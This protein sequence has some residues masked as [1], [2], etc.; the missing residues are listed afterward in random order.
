MVWQRVRFFEENASRYTNWA[1]SRRI[2]SR[3]A[4]HGPQSPLS[5][6]RHPICIYCTPLV[7]AF[8]SRLDRWVLRWCPLV[9]RY[10]CCCCSRR[11]CRK[12]SRNLRPRYGS[13]L[14]H[15][16]P[17]QREWRTFVAGV[18]GGGGGKCA[19]RWRAWCGAHQR[20][21]AAA[22]HAAGDRRTAQSGAN[23]GY[24]RRTGIGLGYVPAGGQVL[25]L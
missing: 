4:P 13:F 5:P 25:Y 9:P 2:Y 14:T 17:E 6:L 19:T 7:A 1:V 24:A 21:T 18:A 3:A 23:P 22:A 15:R 20:C 11:C 8:P 12:P 16:D 10:C